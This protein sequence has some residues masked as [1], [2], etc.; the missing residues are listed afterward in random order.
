MELQASKLSVGGGLGAAPSANQPW[1]SQSAA[2]WPHS[3]LRVQ[4]VTTL[5]FSCA[6]RTIDSYK[7]P[8][9]NQTCP[10][11]NLE[12]STKMDA[13][14]RQSY[15]E[16]CSNHKIPTSHELCGKASYSYLKFHRELSGHQRLEGPKCT[17]PSILTASRSLSEVHAVIAN[18]TLQHCT[19]ARATHA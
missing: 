9:A 5:M 11:T 16:S 18:R 7:S 10:E 12:P 6:R 15:V 1:P 14:A 19:L 8:C 3:A 2:T 17:P 4:S 13:L